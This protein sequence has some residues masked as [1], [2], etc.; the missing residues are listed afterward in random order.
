MD[1]R[2]RTLNHAYTKVQFSNQDQHDKAQLTKMRSQ[3]MQSSSNLACMSTSLPKPAAQPTG[4]CQSLH[5]LPRRT[6][7]RLQP[8]STTA[9]WSLHPTRTQTRRT[10]PPRSP[11]PAEK[12][13]RPQPP[14][15]CRQP[16]NPYRQR[17]QPPKRCWQPSRTEDTKGNLPPNCL[18]TE[19]MVITMSST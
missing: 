17:P 10:E 2:R 9:R 4:K 18:R 16:K 15:R 3:L 1:N 11:R 13:R 5:R 6:C 12:L 7:Q 14:E 19:S 8:R